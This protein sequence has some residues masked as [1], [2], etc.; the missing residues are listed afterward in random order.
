MPEELLDLITL[1]NGK[2]VPRGYRG[3]YD[4][5]PYVQGTPP[6]PGERPLVKFPG[7]ERNG[8][9]FGGH[10]SD[11]AY[12]AGSDQEYEDVMLQYN[13]HVRVERGRTRLVKGTP[14]ARPDATE[15][16]LAAKRCV[17]LLCGCVGVGVYVYVCERFCGC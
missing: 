12:S 11:S 6:K 9:V 4:D 3:L 7:K 1:Y 10:E 15:D 8:D 13:E 5:I 17:C 16:P 2:S 14:K